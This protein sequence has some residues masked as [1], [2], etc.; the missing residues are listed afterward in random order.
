MQKLSNLS[1]IANHFSICPLSRKVLRVCGKDAVALVQGLTTNDIFLLN[2]KKLANGSS[3]QFLHPSLF[4]LLLS[5]EGRVLFDTIVHRC[6]GEALPS[7]YLEA[8]NDEID[9]LVQHVKRYKMRKKVLQF[10][11]SSNQQNYLS[12][13][14][15][16][17]IVQI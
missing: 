7:L 15:N 11:P 6:D 4:T 16:N 1:K 3:N 12:K 9:T 10:L 14:L 13:V 2:K 17:G 5:V 8:D